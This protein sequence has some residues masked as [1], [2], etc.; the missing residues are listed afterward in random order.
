M[1]IVKTSEYSSLDE[2]RSLLRRPHLDEVEVSSH[3]SE[4]TKQIFNEALTPVESVERI[5]QDVKKDGDKALLNYIEKIDG[6]KLS[7]DE[8]LVS[9]EEIKQAEERVSKEFLESLQVAIENVRTFHE[10]QLTNSWFSTDSD[11]NIL[12]QRV[13]PLDKVG[14]YVPGGNAPLI[15]TVVMS[16]IPARVAGVNEIWMATPLR[17]G[18]VDPHLLVAAQRCG[19]TKILKAGGAQ[20]IAAL[21]YGTETIPQVDKVVGPG[22]LYVTLAKK[23]VYGRV[24]IES[25]AGPSE[26]L[27]LADETASAQYIAAD[28]LSQAEHDWE[29]ASCLITTSERLANE[30]AAELEKQVEQL[31]TKEIAKISLERWGLLVVA[32]DMDE[33]IELTNIFAAEHLELMVKDPWAVLGKIKNAG[34]V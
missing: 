1:R 18:K 12:G 11:G 8:L 6:Q 2:V 20:A 13:I 4:R 33:A 32:K 16:A 26:I 9:T 21:A 3:A 27:V 25:L 29:A 14:I 5:L 23:M 7:Q 15:S 30:V 10:K 34:A 28:L 22:N 31:S 24:G 17:D 19:V